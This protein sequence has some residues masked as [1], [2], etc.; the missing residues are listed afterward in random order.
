MGPG[1]LDGENK[2]SGGLRLQGAGSLVPVWLSCCVPQHFLQPLGQKNLSA[3]HRGPLAL[4][5]QSSA[6]WV[7]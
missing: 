3:S 6:K 5:I 2:Q 7:L 4:K 1:V